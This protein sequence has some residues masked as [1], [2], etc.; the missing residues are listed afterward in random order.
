[1]DPLQSYIRNYSDI[2]SGWE[3]FVKPEKV[4]YSISRKYLF[5]SKNRESLRLVAFQE[6][7]SKDFYQAKVSTPE[8]L[9]SNGEYVL[10][11]YY[12]D[13]SLQHKLANKYKSQ[14]DLKYRYWKSNEATRAGSYSKEYMSNPDGYQLKTG[15]VV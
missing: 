9:A 13:N 12:L 14:Q 7:E 1:M 15:Q 4:P 11:L 10:C 2:I 6:L 5:F 3:W 8:N